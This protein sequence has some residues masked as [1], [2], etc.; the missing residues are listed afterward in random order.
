MT[1]SELYQDQPTYRSPAHFREILEHHI[2]KLKPQKLVSVG[3][4]HGTAL[5][6][7]SV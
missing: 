6:L 5:G 7:L 2:V 3:H 4:Q 1:L